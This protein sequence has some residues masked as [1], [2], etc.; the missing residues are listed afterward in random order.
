MSHLE[1][2]SRALH[3]RGYTVK[4]FPSKEAVSDYLNTVIDG[5]TVGFGGSVSMDTMHLYESLSPHNQVFSRHH[6]YVL[7]PEAPAAQIYISSVN[8]AAET[9]E[10]I[11]I[12]AIGNRVASTLYGHDKVY[13]I[14][15]RNKIVSTYEEAVWRARNIAGPKNAQRKQMKTPCALRGD[16][17]YNCKSP[18]RICRAMVVLWGPMMEMETEV[19]LV[20]EDLGF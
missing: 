18:D 17:C 19:L 12:D 15:G 8:G 13:L 4:T 20:D 16:H 6:G 9:G 14:I 7:G 3:Q 1:T 11:N 5:K 10:L 2:L